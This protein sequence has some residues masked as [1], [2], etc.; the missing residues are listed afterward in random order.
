MKGQEEVWEWMTIGF[1]NM[2]VIGDS[3]KSIFMGEMKANVLL[4]CIQERMWEQEEEVETTQ[5]VLSEREA[6]KAGGR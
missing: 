1:N 6:E 2:E 4:E 3:E 5:G